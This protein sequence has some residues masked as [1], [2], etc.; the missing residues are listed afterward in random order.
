MPR[1]GRP[2]D[3]AFIDTVI[4]LRTSGETFS[5]IAAAT[6][7]SPQRAHQVWRRHV[8]ALSAQEAAWRDDLAAINAELDPSGAVK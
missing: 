6:G 7:R 1:T 2:R 5:K 8:A 3:A 4:E